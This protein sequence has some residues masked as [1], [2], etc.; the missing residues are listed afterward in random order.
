MK[1]DPVRTT[2]ADQAAAWFVANRETP[3]AAASEEFLQW[4]R[5]SPMHVEEYLGVTQVA[6]DLMACAPQAQ[7]SIDALVERARREAD[8]VVRA[9]DAPEPPRREP[10]AAHWRLLAA[11]AA[12]VAAIGVA[13]L[14]WQR[15]AP[16]PAPVADTQLRLQ[17]RHGEQLTRRL[18]D[19]S[20]LHVNTDSDVSVRYDAKERRVTINQ[21]QVYFEVAHDPQRPFE[22][23]AGVAKVIARGTVF[24]VRLTDE[25]TIVT[26]AEGRVTVAPAAVSGLPEMTAAGAPPRRSRLATRSKWGRISSCTYQRRTG[27]RPPRRL[28]RNTRPRGCAIRLRSRM[29]LWQTLRPSSI[30]TAAHPSRSKVAHCEPCG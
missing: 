23:F 27:N 2:V 17:T 4:L 18:S 5:N 29:N 6:R 12:L 30:A 25:S 1:E 11:A 21:G 22:V 9:L 7:S 15:T 26:V 24:D 14:L 3:G 20:V 19:S 16:V 8:S 10:R 28:T 13:T